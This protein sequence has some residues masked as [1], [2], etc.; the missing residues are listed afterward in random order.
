M[1]DTASFWNILIAEMPVE[2]PCTALGCQ[3]GDDGG[4]YKT[5]ALE[6]DYALKM[7]DRHRADVH[8][9]QGDRDGGGA[10]GGAKIQLSKIP[11]PDISGGSSQE[12]FKYFLRQWNQYVRA[13][14]ETNDTKL[15]DQL[16]H[17][18]DAALKKAVDRALGD[19][20]DTI[21]VADLLKEIETLAVIRQSNHVNTLALMKAKQERDEPVRQFAARLRGLAAVCDLTATCTCG[22]K[23]SE[24]NKW[25]LMSLIGG[26]NDED[27]KQAVLSKVDEMNLDDTVVFVEARETGKHSV[28]IL[29]GGLASGQV[30]RVQEQTADQ[31]KCRFC[32]RRG[33]GKNPNPDLRKASCP[34][35]GQKCKNCGFSGHFRDQCK[36][37]P[38]ETKSEDPKKTVAKNNNVSINRMQMT[39]SSGKILGVKKS[40]ESLMRKQQNMTRLRHEVWNE[41][42]QTYVKSE[43][44]EE[45]DLKIRMCVDFLAYKKHNP[46]LKCTVKQEWKDNLVN[47]QQKDIVLKTSTADTGAQC[48]LLGRDH[49]PGLGLDVDNLLRSEINLNCA[50][51]TMAGNLGVFY[52]KIRGE[53]YV[54]KESVEARA[55]VYVIE[56]NIV[57]VSRSVLEM[58]GCIPKHFPRVGEFLEPG[59]KAL[60]GKFAHKELLEAAAA[61]SIE[62]IY[63]EEAVTPSDTSPNTSAGGRGGE[64][65]TLGPYGDDTNTPLPAPCRGGRGEGKKK[66]TT[67]STSVVH[68]LHHQI[69]SNIIPS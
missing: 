60:N 52:A 35:H 10:G 37:K 30:N 32:G 31:E 66:L 68:H 42:T 19:R 39:R 45:P 16:L 23:M 4:P 8:G 55:M 21:N 11:R 36:K 49:L 69:H 43:L 24:V 3:H 57:L 9:V 53:H 5:P 26:L 29:S 6:V 40:S 17:C 50:N 67:I 63:K 12:D 20:A 33:H 47:N 41:N 54:T 13:S 22:L 59:N 18:P 46:P 56:G 1:C 15:R 38:S 48:F 65:G 62:A 28:K 51:S 27:T 25:V 64:G 34:A 7:L 2:L 58:L 44:P 61:K 14:N